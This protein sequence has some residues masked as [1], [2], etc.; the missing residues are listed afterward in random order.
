M[1]TRRHFIGSALAAATLLPATLRSPLAFGDSPVAPR[2]LVDWHSHYVSRAE[3]RYLAAR[4]TAPRLLTD[5]DGTT[6]LENVTTVSAA[7]GEPAHLSQSDIAARLANLDA[8]GIGRQLLTQ[9]VAMGFDATLPVAD[10][11]KLYRAYNDELAGVV[12]QH[13]TR[14]LAVAALPSADPQW[15][16]EE[17]TRAHRELGFIG[18][19]LPLNAF[20]TLEGAR[21][22]APLFAAAQKYSSHFF[23]HRGPA[24][25]QVPGQPPLLVPGDTAYA[26]WN[27]INNTHLAQGAITLGLTDFLD[28]Y[29]DVSVEIIM[30]G[31]FLPHLIDTIVPAAR[32]N[33]VKD[34]LAKLRRIYLDSGPYSVRNSEWVALAASKLGADRILFG[35]DYG[36]GGGTRGDVG[37][38][39]QT[40]DRVLTEDQRRLIYFDNSRALLAAKG[41]A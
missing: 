3:L 27:L 19:S 14:F 11:R 6:R 8:H 23:I 25:Q 35:T 18:G 37:P 36:V 29:P 30:L 12:A 1:T 21:T 2:A 17:L 34:P 31:G 7:A 22:L 16:A 24:S 13:K 38:A 4:K 41:I 26:R 28:P 20:A 15:A 40:L 9:T 5:A 10:L 32:S 33:G 39:L